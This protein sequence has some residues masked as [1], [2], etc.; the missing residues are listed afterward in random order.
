MILLRLIIYFREEK[1]RLASFRNWPTSQAPLV[2]FLAENGFYALDDCRVKCHFCGVS[3]DST[4][5]EDT[6]IV[7]IHTQSDRD[8]PFVKDP[9]STDNVIEERPK[10]IFYYFFLFQPKVGS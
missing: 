2:D 9:K 7:A 1:Q 4:E 10:V 5:H 6:D 3:V 8:C